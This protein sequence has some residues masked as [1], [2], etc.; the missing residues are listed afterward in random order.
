MDESAGVSRLSWSA[1]AVLGFAAGIL[2]VVVWVGAWLWLGGDP[3]WTPKDALERRIVLGAAALPAAPSGGDFR[4]TSGYRQY[5]ANCVRCHG[6]PGGGR[7]A[8]ALDMDPAPADLVAGG[9]R[10]DVRQIFWILCHGEAGTGM[11]SFRAHRSNDELW[12]L[13]LFVH[14][15]P[16][17]GS[18]AYEGLKATWPPAPPP[19]GLTADA[20]CYEKR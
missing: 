7:E 4:R 20:S 15:L 16:S 6:E 12:N 14:D 13:A 17:L 19:S 3:L 1:A 8:W 10:R 18:D 2:A 11:P 9:S 5:A